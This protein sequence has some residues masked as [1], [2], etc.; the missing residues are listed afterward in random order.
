[1]YANS[2]HTIDYL[3]IFGRGNIASVDPVL[4]WDPGNPGPVV[5]KIRYDSGDVGLYEG[6]WHGPGPW[7]VAVTTAEKRWEMRPLEQLTVQELGHP[8]QSVDSDALDASFK[9]GFHRQAQAA[10]R[11]A[12]GESSDAVSLADAIET[13]CLIER[14]FA[15]S[16]TAK[17]KDENDG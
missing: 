17:C 1:M 9:P 14:I 16:G 6:I 7:A 2:I 5:C 8:P 11:A 3:R 13:M 15:K 10:V 12:R 4:R